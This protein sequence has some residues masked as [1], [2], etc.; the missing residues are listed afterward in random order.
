[1][2]DRTWSK[3]WSLSILWNSRR[4]SCQPLLI[5]HPHAMSLT[6]V[7]AH[8]V[9]RGDACGSLGSSGQH[10]PALLMLS[11]FCAPCLHIKKSSSACA[12][13]PHARD[14][15]NTSTY[16]SRRFHR[17]PCVRPHANNVKEL[18]G[19]DHALVCQFSGVA[20]LGKLFKVMCDLPSGVG[21]LWLFW[22]CEHIRCSF[23]LIQNVCV[24]IIVCFDCFLECLLWHYFL[25]VR[26]FLPRPGPA[27]AAAGQR[28]SGA[29]GRSRAFLE[30]C[31]SLGLWFMVYG[32]VFRVW[33]FGFK[34]SLCLELS[35]H[36]S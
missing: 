28:A 34:V 18:R 36:V 8:A 26:A 21:G 13:G 22:L 10:H 20:D 15:T 17:R 11:S 4:P 6:A 30:S 3:T 31:R 12:Q 14:L 24:Y 1:M 9:Q 2:H 27:G 16:Q 7:M 32:L 23:V 35:V 29:R 5:K 25:P 19:L 33:G